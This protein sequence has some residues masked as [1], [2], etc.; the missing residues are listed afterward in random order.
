MNELNKLKSNVQSSSNSVLKS[1]QKEIFKILNFEN[2]PF[3]RNNRDQARFLNYVEESISSFEVIMREKKFFSELQDIISLNQK[4]TN[5]SLEDNL[6]ERFQNLKRYNEF[7][8]SS[9]FKIL[10]RRAVQQYS[11]SISYEELY[12]YLKQKENNIFE[13][14]QANNKAIIDKFINMIP[15]L[16]DMAK[17]EE[18]ESTHHNIIIKC[19]KMSRVLE[20]EYS[21]PNSPHKNEIVMAAVATKNFLRQLNK[22][23]F[24]SLIKKDM[25]EEEIDTFICEQVPRL[26]RTLNSVQT[27]EVI[28]KPQE[29]INEPKEETTQKDTRGDERE[30]QLNAFLETLSQVFLSELSKIDSKL[31]HSISI[32]PQD[33]YIVDLAVEN[34]GYVTKP[35]LNRIVRELNKEIREHSQI[36]SL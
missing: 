21:K 34:L 25:T 24:D 17:S 19:Q 6:R 32:D 27:K 13:M 5:I 33:D 11:A 31:V 3:F 26:S 12:S 30:Q 36:R 4:E 20:K 9:D 7:D 15:T 18:L 14:V 22:G 29:V 16:V 28:N 2:Q 10:A 1:M 23:V 8:L 35:E